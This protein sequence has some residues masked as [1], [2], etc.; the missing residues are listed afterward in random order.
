MTSLYKFLKG[1]ALQ[2]LPDSWLQ[3]IKARHYA[4]TL[5]GF[6]ERD[7]PDLVVVRHLVA[8]GDTAIDL[9]ANVG[10]YTKILSGLVGAAGRVISVEPV[11]QTF[12]ILA[13]N[14][15]LLRL[16]NATPINLAVSNKAGV[17]TMTIPSYDF[18]GGNF[19]RAEIVESE[20]EISSDAA[21]KK[22]SVSTSTLDSIAKDLPSISFIK[23]DVEG[24]EEA[25][26]EGAQAVCRD[27]QPAWLLEVRGDP[28]VDGS[29]AARV[30]SFFIGRSYSAWLFDGRQVRR[31]RRGD[32]S[33][34][35]FFLTDRHLG[36]LRNKAHALLSE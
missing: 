13:S 32:Q 22:V 8:P 6:D 25:C 23:C 34:N 7:E 5:R 1:Q 11:P 33:T 10:I 24:H 35:Y 20:G 27:R 12:A 17:V 31:R 29:S 19:Y 21:T 3:A 26:L 16:T 36:V 15:R 14:I 4:R 9:G 18:G 28:D 2:R 30:F